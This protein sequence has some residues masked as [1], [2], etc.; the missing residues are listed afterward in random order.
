MKVSV[1]QISETTGFSSATVSNALNHKKGVNKETSA[2]IFRVAKELGYIPENKITKIKFVIYKRTGAIIDDSP[3]FNLLIDGVEKECRRFGYEMVICHLDRRS[4]DYEEQVRW[5]LN[6]TASAVMLLGTEFMEDDIETY[7]GAKCPFLLFDYFDSEMT[8]DGVLIN[9]TDSARVA[10]EYLIG[11]GHKCI[12]YLRGDF[13][14][15]AFRS[16]AAGYARA[17]HNHNLTADS[18]YTFTLDTTMDGAYKRF[19]GILKRRPALPTA[20]FA[21]NDMIALGAMKALQESGYQVP[22]DVS[23][24]GFDD[25]PFCEI[26]SPRLT[27]IHVSKPEMGAAAVRRMHELI[28][29]IGK[30]TEK[31]SICTDFIERDSVKDIRNS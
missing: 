1:K 5:L 13:R 16:R 29:H 18:R 21:D 14:I 7:R 11:K 4:E 17:L 2:E 26:A 25:L 20:F 9:N 28:E 30:G 10:T 31:I 15:Q 6:D 24:V 8:M 27:T 19:L 3:F 12:G 23:I 22:E